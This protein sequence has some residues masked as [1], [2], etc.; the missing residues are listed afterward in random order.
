MDVF[1]LLDELQTVARNGLAY[2]SNPY[3]VER[4][5]YLLELASRH[6]SELLSLP[7]AEVKTKLSAELGHI[8]PKLG[9]AAAVFDAEGRVLLMERSDGSGWCLPCGWVEP[10][11]RPADAAVREVK[12]ETGLDVR[13]QR[14]VGVF[15]RTSG[16]FTGLHAMAAVVH[17]CEVVGGELTLSVEGLSLRY[18]PLQ[19]VP[20][21]AGLHEKKARAAHKLW[22]SE[23]SLPAVS[24]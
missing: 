17:L 14:L 12:E 6:Y 9:A 7:T 22:A 16:Q 3:D 13:V 11:E 23:L 1:S 19:D 24:D 15:T 18:W 21:W 20:R 4:Y 2:A 8:T 10:N 5:D